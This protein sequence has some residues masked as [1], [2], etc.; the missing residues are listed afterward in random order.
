MRNTGTAVYIS[1]RMDSLYPGVNSRLSH[2]VLCFSIFLG[3]GVMLQSPVVA[4]SDTQAPSSSAI[5]VEMLL[6]LFPLVEQASTSNGFSGER[7]VT[8]YG[9]EDTTRRVEVEESIVDTLRNQDAQSLLDIFNE[10]SLEFNFEKSTETSLALSASVAVGAEER[11]AKYVSA[12]EFEKVKHLLEQEGVNVNAAVKRG[13]YYS[14]TPITL[15][16]INQ[17]LNMVELLLRHGADPDAFEDV[18]V[19]TALGH[20]VKGHN[21]DLTRVLLNAGASTDFDHSIIGREPLALWA[22]QTDDLSL[23]TLLIERGVNPAISGNQGWTPLSE[24]IRLN[25]VKMAEFLVDMN[26]PRLLTAEERSFSANS[27][28]DGRYFP[29]SNALFLARH[30]LEPNSAQQLIDRIKQRTQVLGGD[31][32]VSLLDLRAFS[33]ASQLAY[34]ELKLQE[35]VQHRLSALSVVDL[36]SLDSDS[37]EELIKASMLMLVNLHELSVIAGEPFSPGSRDM[38]KHLGQIDDAFMKWHDMLD[39]MSAAGKEDT[40][41]L[42]AD[43]RAEHGDPAQEGWNYDM[44][45]DW[46]DGVADEAERG[47][48]YETIDVFRSVSVF[49]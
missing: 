40:T 27:R 36:L 4:Q 43:W 6:E 17:D 25:N 24:A 3:L 22:A 34:A 11:L 39:I 42:I 46:A 38:T 37:D 41:S 16:A 28:F 26:D 31:V 48:L 12:R 10:H 45:L 13:D 18:E 21:V 20:A 35:A 5:M 33:S 47:R 23:M 1:T 29:R 49:K 8:V 14:F 7:L 9:L 15:A 2:K 19:L 30:F 32:A 44:L